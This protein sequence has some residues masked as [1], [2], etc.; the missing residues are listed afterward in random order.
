[1]VESTKNKKTDKKLT[2]E[3]V[4]TKTTKSKDKLEKTT[5]KVVDKKSDTKVKKASKKEDIKKSEKNTSK[6]TVKKMDKSDKVTKIEKVE[7]HDIKD[8]EKEDK[9]HDKKEDKHDKKVHE[10]KDDKDDKKEEKEIKKHDKK[11][12]EEEH[13]KEDKHTKKE[14][15]HSD[16]KKHEKIKKED[17]KHIEK[18]EEKHEKNSKSEKV[19]EHEKVEK[20]E[21][22]EKKV[23]KHHLNNDTE[24]HTK[25][26]KKSSKS[27][28]AYIK[29]AFCD[30][31]M[32][33]K[34]FFHWNI[35]KILIFFWSIALGFLFVLP[36]IFIFIVYS[37]LYHVDSTQLIWGMF[38]GNPMNN[39]F[40]NII[41]MLIV[42]VFAIIYSYWNILLLNVNNSYI[43][44]KKLEFKKNDYFKFH[45]VIK[46]FNLTVLNALILLLPILTVIV[47][48]WILFLISGDMS[49]IY[50]MVSSSPINYFTILSFVIAFLWIVWFVYITYRTIFSYLVYLEESHI[51]KKVKLL[52]CIKISFNK[53]KKFKS[54]FK[55]L[56]LIVLFLI[57][58]LPIKFVWVMLDNNLKMVS[59]YSVYQNLSE[60]NKEKVMES[61]S[62][63]YSALE[64]EFR[65][66]ND[67]RLEKIAR[68]N[69]IH[70]VLFTI[71]SFLFLNWLFL[72]IMTS[73][74]KRE[75][76]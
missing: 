44:W 14:E 73:F 24:E 17:E 66:Y 76:K 1:M 58:S 50:E 54:F 64:V 21:K 60:E 31:A 16:E 29:N 42:I 43:E 36:F 28:V 5:D 32:L 19:S 37:F 63:Y 49:Q 62:N 25:K 18:H 15:K 72:M 35:S 11:H 13:H 48:M 75:L 69:E 34:N 39:F 2:E 74:Y 9:N 53:T 56:V 70:M 40:W 33:Y 61:N 57:I 30:S 67:E 20:V 6:D 71:L 46:F 59:D 65:W 45:K 26:E 3:V 41:L 22:V 12:S 10:K 51:S 23:T 4:K 8:H 47:L 52:D 68:K 38:N 7:K 27:C 55:F